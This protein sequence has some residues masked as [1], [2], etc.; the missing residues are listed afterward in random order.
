MPHPSTTTTLVRRRDWLRHN[1]RLVLNVVYFTLLGLCLFPVFGRSLLPDEWRVSGAFGGVLVGVAGNLLAHLI[2]Q[3]LREKHNPA[4]GRDA[5]TAAR[6]RYLTGLRAY[7]QSL[8][9]AALGQ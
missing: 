6:Y 3:G 8:P 1:L 2:I 7:C 4:S 9:L 5:Q